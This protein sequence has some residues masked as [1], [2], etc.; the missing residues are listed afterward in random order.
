L[1]REAP[2]GRGPRRW[3]WPSRSLA[4][5]RAQERPRLP[6]AKPPPA[7]PRRPGARGQTQRCKAAAVRA[8]QAG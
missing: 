3:P 4:A 5:T 2:R 7:G 1:T 8:P 6:G